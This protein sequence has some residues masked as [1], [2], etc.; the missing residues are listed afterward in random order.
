[1]VV[2]WGECGGARVSTA[3]MSVKLEQRKFKTKQKSQTKASVCSVLRIVFSMAK[4]MIKLVQHT[5]SLIHNHVH[6]HLHSYTDPIFDCS[7]K[8]N[9]C[10][11]MQAKKMSHSKKLASKHTK[12]KTH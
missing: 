9:N 11:E 12:K 2:E 8:L 6:R 10:E 5:H 7:P 4:N 1:M 3:G